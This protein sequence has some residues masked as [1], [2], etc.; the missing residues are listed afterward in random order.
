[1]FNS[2]CQVALNLDDTLAVLKYLKIKAELNTSNGQ[3]NI[4]IIYL[5]M[6]VLYCFDLSFIEN[7]KQQQQG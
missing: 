1:M 4:E 2:A 3:L 6:A 5:L 7:N